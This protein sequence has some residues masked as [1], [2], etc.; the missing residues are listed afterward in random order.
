M[1]ERKLESFLD[2]WIALAGLFFFLFLSFFPVWN[3][4]F[5][6][7]Q[8]VLAQGDKSTA[9]AKYHE[10]DSKTALQGTEFKLSSLHSQV[11]AK[12]YIQYC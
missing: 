11:V 8:A 2:C 9:L 7:F 12:N 4:T 5:D 1:F 3:R 10:E 6:E